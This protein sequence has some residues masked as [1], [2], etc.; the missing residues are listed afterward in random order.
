MRRVERGDHGHR[1]R[2]WLGVF[3]ALALAAVALA[4][5]GNG[6]NSGTMAAIEKAVARTTTTEP[7]ATTTTSPSTHPGSPTS[8]PGG[9]TTTAPRATTTLPGRAT[10]TTTTRATP[11]PPLPSQNSHGT[12][13]GEAAVA[14]IANVMND[15]RGHLTFTL[16]LRNAGALP[17]NCAALKAVAYT[18]TGRSAIVAPLAGATGL[19]CPSSDDTLPP[20]GNQTFAFDIPLVGGAAGQVAALPFGSFASK[21]A[22]SLTTT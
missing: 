14:S 1:A 10:T 15:G 12:A 18:S 4:A 13:K 6:A 8:V 20:G 3:G 2:R 9:V 5:C 11:E 17:Y 16:N 7:Q 19:A 21:V 22:W